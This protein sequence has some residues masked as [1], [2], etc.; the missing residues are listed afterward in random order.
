[1][2]PAGLRAWAADIRARADDQAQKLEAMALEL[3]EEAKS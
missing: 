2:N 1:M 3:E